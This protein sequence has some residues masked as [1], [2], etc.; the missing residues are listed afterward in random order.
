MFKI[1]VEVLV[2]FVK[3]ISPGWSAAGHLSRFTDAIQIMEIILTNKFS[4]IRGLYEFLRVAKEAD[5]DS[6]LAFPKVASALMKLLHSLCAPENAR[7]GRGDVESS[8]TVIFEITGFC[9]S[10]A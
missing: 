8:F 9:V 10:G 1:A 4:C 7:S 3:S 6:L 5:V 2:H